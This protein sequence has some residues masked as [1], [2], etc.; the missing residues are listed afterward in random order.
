MR[1]VLTER[2]WEWYLVEAEAHCSY[3]ELFNLPPTIRLEELP[4]VGETPAR[5][6][7]P[8]RKVGQGSAPI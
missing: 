7:D 5:L 3:A 8:S 1:Q 4:D 2:E 6:A